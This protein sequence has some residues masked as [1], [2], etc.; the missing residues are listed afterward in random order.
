VNAPS[1]RSRTL[2]G[3]L[4]AALLGA[5][6]VSHTHSVGLGATGTGES[7]A[8]Q[9]YILFGLVP[10]NTVDSQR[11]APELTSYTI[12]TSY[13]FV[14]LLIAPLLLPLTVTTRTV[15]VRT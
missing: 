13:G 1:L 9:F 4:L 15:V 2:P 11:L 10:V 3:L 6:C 14:D 7:S 5:G 8:R 12:E